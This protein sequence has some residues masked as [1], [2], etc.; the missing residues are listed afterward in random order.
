MAALGLVVV[1]GDLGPQL[2]LADVHL[3]LV[4][5]GGLRLLLLL[6][7]VLRVVEDAGDRRL[8]VR[9]DL[10]QVEVPLAGALQRVLGGDDPDLLP[11]LV[12]QADLGTRIRSLI[13]VVS[14]SGGRRSK[15]ETATSCA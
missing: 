14:R 15:R 6:V 3:L 1:L 12:D 7:L 11:A 4:L 2:D 13:R 8:R 10:D 5:A 9:S